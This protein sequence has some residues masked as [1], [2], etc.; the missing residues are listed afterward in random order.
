MVMVFVSVFLFFS[1]SS[2]PAEGHLERKIRAVCP[3]VS[4]TILS[5]L[6]E[7]IP[8][9]RGDI[10]EDLIVA[11]AKVE[12]TCS[13]PSKPGGAGEWG[14]LQVIPHD[15]HI[16]AA[17]VEYRCENTNTEKVRFNGVRVPLCLPDGRLNIRVGSSVSLARCIAVLQWSPRLAFR[18]GISELKYWR[19][20]YENVYKTR[21]W[22]SKYLMVSS[23]WYRSVRKRLGDNVF[24]THHNWGPRLILGNTYPL[25][26]AKEMEKVKEVQ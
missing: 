2:A 24:V 19:G 5:I 10:S 14:I 13:H 15:R 1:G 9:Y 6:T 3:E 21:Y 18:I 26:I 7:D 17:L 12:T 23:V 4:P 11:V 25:R 16:V 8:D 20:M 22:S